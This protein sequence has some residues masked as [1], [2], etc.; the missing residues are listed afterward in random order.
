MKSLGG[1]SEG[2]LM[3]SMGHP[4]L[5]ID[6]GDRFK[7][8]AFRLSD[9][10]V[11]FDDC[12]IPTLVRMDELH[13]EKTIGRGACSYVQRCRHRQTGVPYACKIFSLYDE[14]TRAQLLR[15][16]TVLSVVECPALVSFYG[17]FQNDGKVGMVLEYMDRGTLADL[18]ERF[19]LPEAVLASA[20]YQMT[21]GLAYLHHEGR[22]HRDLKPSNVLVNSRGEVKLS[23]FGIA[24]TL[25]TKEGMASTMVGTF[26]YMSPERLLGHA[27]GTNSDMWSLGITILELWFRRQPFEH[28]ESPIEL[29]QT[30]EEQ[31]VSQILLPSDGTVP[32][33]MAET[34]LSCLSIAPNR[35]IPADILLSSPWLSEFG[36]AGAQAYTNAVNNTREWMESLIS[37][38]MV[39]SCATAQGDQLVCTLDSDGELDDHTFT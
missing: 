38:D 14:A 10:G 34:I 22:L 33:L 1:S 17:A 18:T 20:T 13:V 15:E 19:I 21:W 28:V 6:P 23:D 9:D 25:E 29:V 4:R 8:P 37:D 30:L 11:E 31:E 16:I 7:N 2:E 3:A 39:N 36:L 12:V 24:T 27:Y 32:E 35:R 26:K 5:H